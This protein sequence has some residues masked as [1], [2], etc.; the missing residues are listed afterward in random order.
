MPGDEVGLVLKMME[1]RKHLTLAGLQQIAVIVQ[2]INRQKPPLFLES[3]ETIRQV[4]AFA[5]E[6]IV[7]AV[8]RRTEVGRNDRPLSS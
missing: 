2:Q 1:E 4:P 7:R 8:R 3:S 6:D 5:G